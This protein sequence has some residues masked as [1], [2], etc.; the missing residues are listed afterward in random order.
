M[1]EHDTATHAG[2]ASAYGRLAIMAVA[3]FVAMYFL[4][5]AM[6]D[7]PSSVVMNL[8]QV[9]M[10]ALM[11]APMVL[12][13]LLVMRSMYAN[14]RRN[15]VLWVV[16]IA[17]GVLAF[18]AIR[19]QTAIGDRQFARSMIPHHSGAILMCTQAEI[20]SA[21]LRELCHGP[22]GI[23]ASQRKEIA[24]LEAFLRGSP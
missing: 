1:Q 7:Q 11:A 24:Q 13:E 15:A 19:A 12:I 21:E 20:A 17:L 6:V 18:V 3:S 16:T 22:N 8:N 5:Y 9:Y 4:M 2:Q 23:V 10:A 14:G